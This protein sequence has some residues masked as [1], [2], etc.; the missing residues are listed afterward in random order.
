MSPRGSFHE[1]T[2][3][4][5]DVEFHSPT[6]KNIMETDNEVF[7]E[8]KQWEQESRYISQKQ[9]ESLAGVMDEEVIGIITM[10]DV[11]E[12]LLQVI[13]VFCAIATIFLI[14]KVNVDNLIILHS[15]S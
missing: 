15:H 7:Q 11:M 3:A 9:M 5:S 14:K 10:E 4:S 8:S 6:L 12:E 1:S 2:L 13:I